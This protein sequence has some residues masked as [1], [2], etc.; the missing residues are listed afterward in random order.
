MEWLWQ[1]APQIQAIFSV[2]ASTGAIAGVIFMLWLRRSTPSRREVD[3][4][5]AALK[6]EIDAVKALATEGHERL[7]AAEATMQGLATKEDVSK[8]L[9]ALERQDGDRRELAAEIRG[10]REVFKRI[11][12]P[13][14][15]MMEAALSK[16]RGR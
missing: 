2:L 11:E 10:I 14:S 9:Q 6:S 1:N 16:E 3:A 7:N 5:V 12:T 8:I 4:K 13:L 15:M